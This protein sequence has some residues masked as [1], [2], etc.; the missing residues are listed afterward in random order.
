MT[1]TRSE[2]ISLNASVGRVKSLV[3]GVEKD[4]EK[5]DISKL[6]KERVV[7]FDPH[8]RPASDFVSSQSPAM[9]DWLDH[10]L[11]RVLHPN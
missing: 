9:L 3:E 2:N 4:G 6:V 5:G 11:H 1:N 10:L 7:V 8:H